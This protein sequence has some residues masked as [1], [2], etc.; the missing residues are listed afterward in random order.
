[1]TAENT[2]GPAGLISRH[3][4]SARTFYAFDPTGNTAERLDYD[5]TVLSSAQYD[6]YGNLKSGTSPDPFGYSGEWGGYTD[7]ETGLVLLT[8]RFYDPET[9]RFLTR[10]PL[11]YAG[12]IN[13]YG[14]VQDNPVNWVDPEGYDPGTDILQWGEMGAGAG[15]FF[16]PE[17]PVGGFVSVSVTGASAVFVG[18]YVGYKIDE[19]RAHRRIKSKST[20]GRH[21]NGER[22]RKMRDKE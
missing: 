13:L 17:G 22:Q 15:S 16:G 14:Y 20:R 8:H 11:G 3:V 19:S 1:V 12:G 18:D 5:G 10:D 21:D 2:F 7:S 4:G 9:G 6:A